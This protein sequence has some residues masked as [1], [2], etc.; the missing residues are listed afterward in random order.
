PFRMSIDPITGRMYFGDVGGNDANTAVEEIN[1]G[2]AGANYGWPLCEGPCP[3]EPGVTGPVYS[4]PHNGR[5][6]SVVG[7]FV[8]RGSQFPSEYLGGYF[9]ADYS[10]NWIKRLTLDANG[11]ATGV[12]NFEPVDGT[13]DGPYGDPVQL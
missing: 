7:G 3:Q 6:A 12:Q 5:D 4:Y 1:L 10:Q 13:P 9:F 8:Y 11:F 2:V